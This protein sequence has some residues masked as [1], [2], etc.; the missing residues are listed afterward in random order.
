MTTIRLKP[1]EI[2]ELKLGLPRL[3][4]SHR[5]QEMVTH[6]LDMDKWEQV[7][8]ERRKVCERL[9]KLMVRIS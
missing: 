1:D 7:F 2:A 5:H 3:I 8:K 9:Y 4:E 6:H